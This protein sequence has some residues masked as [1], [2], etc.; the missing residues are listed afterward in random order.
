MLLNVLR[1]RSPIYFILIPVIAFLLWF[2]AF[3]NP[4]LLVA[5]NLQTPLYQLLLCIF[6]CNPLYLNILGYII[7]L[8]VSYK[9]TQLNERFVFIKQKTDL[10]AILFVIIISC[11]ILT[12]GLHP[13]LIS[14]LF[15]LLSVNRIFNIYHSN[16]SVSYAFDAGLLIGLSSLFYLPSILFLVWFVWSLI[17]LSSF[18]LK[19]LISGLIGFITPIF[20]LVCW[21]F[22]RGNLAYLFD[23][24]RIITEHY[25]HLDINSTSQIIFGVILTS[26]S[27]I[28]VIFTTWGFEEKR[29]RSRKYLLTLV[30]LFMTSITSGILFPTAI[31]AEV[32]VAAVPLS[33]IFTYF[34][35]MNRS[36]KISEILFGIL[37]LSYLLLKLL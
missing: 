14:S 20:F 23:Q 15:L 18:R 7:I 26:L 5:Y 8:F 24:T 16:Q 2:N 12:N 3:C 37:I 9:L 31:I 29:V 33:Y 21:Y 30:A 25:E 6:N 35:I 19:E 4:T 27:L 1:R 17:I 32:F 34:F 22:W 28:A 10:P 13:A 36:S 11:T